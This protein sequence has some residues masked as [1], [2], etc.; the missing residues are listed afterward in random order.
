MTIY[1][2]KNENKNQTFSTSSER[3]LNL[4]TLGFSFQVY[5]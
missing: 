4:K 5:F 3:R 1:K 2:A